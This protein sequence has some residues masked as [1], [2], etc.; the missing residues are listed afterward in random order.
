M[1]LG[2]KKI[3][4]GLLKEPSK[5]FSIIDAWIIAKNPTEEQKILAESRFNVCV[6]CEEFR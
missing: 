6:L 5:V 2:L 3:I 1:N 4:G